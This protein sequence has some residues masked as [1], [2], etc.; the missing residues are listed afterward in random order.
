[1]FSFGGIM[2]RFID[3]SGE[4]F[5]RLTAISH[6]G[7]SNHGRSLWLC[8]CDCGNEKVIAQRSL[9]A[10]YTK[11]CGCYQKEVASIT[12]PKRNKENAKHGM[13]GTKVYRVWHMMLQRCNNAKNK[14]FIHY[15]GR[16]VSVCAEWFDFRSF[17]R[18]MGDIPSPGMTIERVN[19][20]GNYEP[21][22]C[23][24]A[25]RKQQRLNQR[26]RK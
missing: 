8:L 21:S 6:A 7:K 16:G 2:Q 19:N 3:L 15:G 25:T 26:A 24:W 20:D 12:A 23:I 5:G 11:S 14:D 1:M 18:D 9:I 4:K 17:Y 22:N 13:A 10:G